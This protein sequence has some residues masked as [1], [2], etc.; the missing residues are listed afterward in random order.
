MRFRYCSL[1]AAAGVLV[2]CGILTLAFNSILSDNAELFIE[3]TST[4][5]AIVSALLLC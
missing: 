4:L 2:L 3:V 5:F 1:L